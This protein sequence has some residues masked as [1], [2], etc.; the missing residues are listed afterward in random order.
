M[1]G[2]HLTSGGNMA[3]GNSIVATMIHDCESADE[4]QSSDTERLV[5]VASWI[6]ERFPD[7]REVFRKA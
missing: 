7:A 6:V 3:A 1:G 4:I 2:Y 5:F